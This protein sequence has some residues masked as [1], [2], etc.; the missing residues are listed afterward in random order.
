MPLEQYLVIKEAGV[1]DASGS[2]RPLGSIAMLD[3]DKVKE[4]ARHVVKAD[5]NLTPVNVQMAAIAPSGPNPV[6]PQQIPPDALQT[7]RGYEQPGAKLVG[8]VTTPE[9]V[10][11]EA[12]GLL[13]DDDDSQGQIV[14]AVADAKAEAGKSDKAVAAKPAAKK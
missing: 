11:L 12:A 2:L 14:E 9:A 13:D 5:K 10:R 6:N 1:F 3:S 4:G 7:I 8:E